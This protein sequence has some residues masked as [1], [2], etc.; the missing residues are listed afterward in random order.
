MSSQQPIRDTNQQSGV[1]P[2]IIYCLDLEGVFTPE[3]WVALA[4]ATGHKVFART[5]RDEPDY[6]KLMQTRV[7]ALREHNIGFTQMQSVVETLDPLPGAVEFLDEL[8]AMGP[9]AILSDTFEQLVEPLII[10]LGRPFMLCHQFEIVEDQVVAARLRCD[11]P[12]R[13]AVL[14]FQSLGYRVKAVGDS[15][16]DISMLAAADEGY[17]F[18][19]SQT[20]ADAHPEFESETDY[21][22]LLK[23]LTDKAC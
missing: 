9:V 3:I 18:R 11:D 6:P 13:K 21:D 23:L 1:E 20:V 17:L 12:K 19:T 10:K 4:E 8:R 7:D 5:T 2:Q 14:G 15:F 16:N 22:S